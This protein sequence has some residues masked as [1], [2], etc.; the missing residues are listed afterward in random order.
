L[1]HAELFFKDG[2]QGYL[3]VIYAGIQCFFSKAWTIQKVDAG[4]RLDH[5]SLSWLPI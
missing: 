2:S 4:M 5:P 1:K 3:V